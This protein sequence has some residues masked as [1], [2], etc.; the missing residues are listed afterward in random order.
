MRKLSKLSCLLI[1][2][3]MGASLSA[4]AATWLTYNTDGNISDQTV[5][6]GDNVIINSTQQYD[7]SYSPG[8]V[9]V[10]N[11]AT[12]TLNMSA[13]DLTGFGW[14]KVGSGATAVGVV[15][16]S[17]GTAGAVNL[18][19]GEGG[20]SGTYNMSGGILNVGTVDAGTYLTLLAN[21]LINFSGGTST[22]NGRVSCGST[23]TIRVTGSDAT[24]NLYQATGTMAGTYEFIFDAAGVS[25]LDYSSYV[26]FAAGAKLVVD[27]SAYTRGPASFTLIDTYATGM[28]MDFAAE[29]ITV[30][31]FPGGYTLEQNAGDV[32]L[33]D[34]TPRGTVISIQ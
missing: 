31:G 3:I 22:I 17:G 13:N 26:Q 33:N 27:G 24:V 10:G 18:Y 12:G 34:T 14:Y 23:S 2:G 29:N 21:N 6:A 9:L 20:S 16:Q 28:L 1:A 19:L 11:S 4:Q 32:T 15:N 8:L 25:S 30:T 7:T 5:N